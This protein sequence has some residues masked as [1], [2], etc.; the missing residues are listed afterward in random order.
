MNHLN[1]MVLLS[2]QNMLKVMFKK[3]LFYIQLK[4]GLTLSWGAYAGKQFKWNFKGNLFSYSDNKK[5]KNT[6][7]NFFDGT[8]NGYE[9]IT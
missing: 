7:C 1:E 9:I 3:Y 5:S 8:L 4:S 6:C 2:T